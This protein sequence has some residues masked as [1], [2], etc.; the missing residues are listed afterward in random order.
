MPKKALQRVSSNSKSPR[1]RIKASPGSIG[2]RK[3]RLKDDVGV[4]PPPVL[5]PEADYVAHAVGCKAVALGGHLSERQADFQI[6]NSGILSMLII[7]EERSGAKVVIRPE[8]VASF[9][10]TN[11]VIALKLRSASGILSRYV[12]PSSSDKS[13]V[14]AQISHPHMNDSLIK[15]IERKLGQL[16]GQLPPTTL[17]V[18]E[19]KIRLMTAQ[20]NIASL[21]NAI[22]LAKGENLESLTDRQLSQQRDSTFFALQT[23]QMALESKFASLLAEHHCVCCTDSLTSILLLPCRHMVLCSDC[24]TQLSKKA[25]VLQCPLCRT[26]VEE[27]HL[28][29]RS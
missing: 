29:Y 9:S 2:R 6:Y 12:I 13:T 5:L 20:N 1:R 28:A 17:G 22:S 25:D 19:C 11:N 10:I 27:H 18:L 21:T 16:Y 24:F 14:V 3:K 15:D 8:E 26:P 7:T 23:V 4:A